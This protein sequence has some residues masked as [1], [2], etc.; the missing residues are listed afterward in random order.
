MKGFR[1][2][3]TLMS[4][5]VA[6][7]LSF[8]SATNEPTNPYK[9]ILEELQRAQDEA[10][11][12]DVLS[13][14]HDEPS[15]ICTKLINSTPL[16][17]LNTLSGPALMVLFRHA[18]IN[19]VIMTLQACATNDPSG[20]IYDR[21]VKFS[22]SRIPEVLH[23][24]SAILAQIA[25]SSTPVSETTAHNIVLAISGFE[26][27]HAL[28]VAEVI[29]LVNAYI[30]L[31][32][33]ASFVGEKNAKDDFVIKSAPALLR[34][35]VTSGSVLEAGETRQQAQALRMVL[36]A[37]ALKCAPDSAYLVDQLTQIG[38]FSQAEMRMIRIVNEK[39]KNAHTV[40]SDPAKNEKEKEETTF[41]PPSESVADNAPPSVVRPEVEGYDVRVARIHRSMP[42]RLRI[43]IIEKDRMKQMLVALPAAIY[44]SLKVHPVDAVKAGALD[45]YLQPGA[46][47]E[48]E[49]LNTP[50][51]RILVFYHIDEPLPVGMLDKGLPINV[52]AGYWPNT[53]ETFVTA[54][55]GPSD[56]QGLSP[57]SLT[58]RT[59]IQARIGPPTNQSPRWNAL[60]RDFPLGSDYSFNCPAALKNMAAAAK[61]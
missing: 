1:M 55:N 47:L 37:E 14:S 2:R 4:V 33:S 34:K 61:P 35:I 31:I 10:A 9:P 6:A 40:D 21:L 11:V 27:S 59:A 22:D 52:F 12:Y 30:A 58:L 24:L 23:T 43:E 36:A 13:F 8:V 7:V 48:F 19:T 49:K 25:I 41:E 60:F 17:R 57:S 20:T 42:Q 18:E 32:K 15:E 38:K 26:K 39:A 56:L 3:F 28:A 44:D 46:F 53:E 29:E 50:S 54:I 5:A 45:S 16:S 51:H